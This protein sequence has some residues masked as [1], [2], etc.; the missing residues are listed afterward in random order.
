[1][2]RTGGAAAIRGGLL[3]LVVVLGLS[4]LLLLHD[5]LLALERP[6]QG[7]A[8]VRV[9]VRQALPDLRHLQ[10]DGP[11]LSGR[12]GLRDL[13]T[14][15]RKATVARAGREIV[16]HGV[17]YSFTALAPY[18]RLVGSPAPP[19]ISAP[20]HRIKPAGRVRF[21]A[22]CCSRAQTASSGSKVGRL[23]QPGAAPRQKSSSGAR[24]RHGERAVRGV[25][26]IGRA[27]RTIRLAGALRH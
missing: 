8:A 17:S 14:F 21:P 2:L 24:P 19:L 7:R 18:M 4:L 5:R 22:E 6:Q 13:Q 10:Q 27:A 12:K 16:R 26:Q 23:S 15:A 20:C 11:T 25:L 1:M 3:F 9:L